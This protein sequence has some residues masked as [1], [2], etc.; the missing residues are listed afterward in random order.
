MIEVSNLHYTY[1]T[2][3]SLR[4]IP[5]LCGVDFAVHRGEVFGFLGPNGA[6]KSTTIR[7][8]L[9]L[10]KPKQGEI[11]LMGG[12]PGDVEVMRR[13]GYLPENPWFYR[14]LTG[15]EL[16]VFF[17]SLFGVSSPEDRAEELLRKVGLLDFADV[18]VG[19]YSKGMVQRIGFAQALVNDPE[20]LILDEPMSGLDPIG[21]HKM[22]EWMLELREAGKTIFFSTHILPDV[23]SLCDRVALLVKGKIVKVGMV[24]DFTVVEDRVQ[25]RV[26]DNGTGEEILSPLC[27]KA[28][29]QGGELVLEVDGKDTDRIVDVIRE[30]KW[31]IVSVI[32]AFKSLE[33]AFAEVVSNEGG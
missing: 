31:H 33:E 3:F 16:L 32:P 19:K 7:L 10:L 18:P 14:H 15:R 6:G 12:R 23:E 4:A 21:R 28:Y 29:R 11:S 5:A 22:K 20:V 24:R 17:G 13:I 9:G 26:Q 25:I 30:N 8:L 2:P 27:H 1:R